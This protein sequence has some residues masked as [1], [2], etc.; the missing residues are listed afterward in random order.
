MLE[1]AVLGQVGIL[2]LIYQHMLVAAGV[3]LAHGLVLFE[4]LGR[5]KQ[6]VIEIHGVVRE[7]HLL[8]TRVDAFDHFVAIGLARVFVGQQQVVLGSGDGAVDGLGAVY[9]FVQVQIAD[10]ALDQA[11][12]VVI[13][14]DDEVGAERQVF[15]FAAQ[16]AGADGVK[17][18]QG[19]A[20]SAFAQ[21][22]DDAPFHLA[23]GLVG[24]GDRQDLVRPH[25]HRADQIGNPLG[26]DAGFAR[27]RASQHQHGAKPRGDGL[28]LLLV[29]TS[30]E[31]HGP[32]STVT[33]G[34][35]QRL[36]R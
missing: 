19:Y 33:Q 11:A 2:E 1:Q 30:K 5:I 23:G 20:A 17:G 22:V 31:I 4:Q 25:A 10:G 8:V 6:Q 16:H 24:E 32:H 35:C 26:Q 13:I 29:E 7:Q 15:G 27:P 21:Q 36:R 28:L 3:L 12:L 34:A 9:F 14:E 18:A